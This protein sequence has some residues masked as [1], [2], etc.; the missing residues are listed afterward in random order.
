ME[1]CSQFM[2]ND[3]TAAN[4]EEAIKFADQYSDLELK[5]T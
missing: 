1:I 2:W 5:V 3:L 4:V